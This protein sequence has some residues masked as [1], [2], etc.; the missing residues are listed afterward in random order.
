MTT[1][2]QEALP[3]PV[4][5]DRRRVSCKGWRCGRE[6]TD[7]DSRRRGYGPECDP[8][9][10]GGHDRRDIDQDPIPGL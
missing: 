2:R 4:S 6:L 10:R 8:D 9:Q 5:G 7:P 1:N 3:A